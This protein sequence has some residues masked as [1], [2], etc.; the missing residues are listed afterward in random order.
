MRR[1][2]REV[3]DNN[4]INEIISMCHCC[5]LGF[6]DAGEVYI[7]PLNFGFAQVDDK[8]I[9]YFHGAKEGRKI[10][11]ISRTHT[12]GFELDTNYNLHKGDTACQYSASF[13]SVIGTGHIDF[14]EDAV[15]K[16]FA[17]QMIMFQS[18]GRKN[19]DFADEILNSTCIFKLEVNAISCKEH[20]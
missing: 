6:N 10:D 18:T 17:L 20:I 4:K 13:M 7:V 3:T 5:R 15:E 1:K 19:W 16:A 2:D 9:F 8:R 14:I 12:A 11:L